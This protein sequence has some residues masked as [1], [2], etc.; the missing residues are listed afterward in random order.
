MGIVIM[1]K[2]GY[3]ASI[4][5]ISFVTGLSCFTTAGVLLGI[6]YSEPSESAVAWSLLCFAVMGMFSISIVFYFSFWEGMKQLHKIRQ[7]SIDVSRS[8]QDF[9]RQMSNSRM[10]ELNI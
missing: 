5:E 10:Y 4:V 9:E 2:L 1:H 6:I 3:E 8:M 7:K